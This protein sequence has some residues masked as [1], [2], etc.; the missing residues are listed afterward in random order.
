[1]ET[2]SEYPRLL[3]ATGRAALLEV[4]A[5]YKPETQSK[6]SRCSLP[7][8]CMSEKRFVKD[9]LCAKGSPVAKADRGCSASSC[10]LS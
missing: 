3:T 6:E 9:R 10:K 5:I 8:T 7:E 4:E 1:M 2:P